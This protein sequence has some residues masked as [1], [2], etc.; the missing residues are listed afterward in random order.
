MATLMWT[1]PAPRPSRHGVTEG[2]SAVHYLIEPTHIGP[3]IIILLAGVA[4][5]LFVKHRRK[6]QR[7]HATKR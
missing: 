2:D 3:A 1:S 7:E 6:L 4:V 5:G